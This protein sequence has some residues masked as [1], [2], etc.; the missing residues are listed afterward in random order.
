MIKV[1]CPDDGLDCIY[2]EREEEG[3]CW[4]CPKIQ[5]VIQGGEGDKGETEER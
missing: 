2:P 3:S 1:L 5:E 4:N